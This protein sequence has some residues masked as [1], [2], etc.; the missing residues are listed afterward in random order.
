MYRRK[1]DKGRMQVSCEQDFCFVDVSFAWVPFVP[2]AKVMRLGVKMCT[3][4]RDSSSQND[5][6]LIHL[7][8][9]YWRLWPVSTK[10]SDRT[11]NV[12]R[13]FPLP[14]QIIKMFFTQRK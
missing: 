3:T 11:L 8:V 14:F 1:D 5:Y 12:H 2:L 10:C 4:K 9:L 13:A 6:L 7:Q